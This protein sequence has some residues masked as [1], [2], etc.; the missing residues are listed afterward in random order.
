[1]R[2]IIFRISRFT[3]K[4]VRCMFEGMRVPRVRDNKFIIID[5]SSVRHRYRYINASQNQFNVRPLIAEWHFR[6]FK[7][8]NMPKHHRM[9]MLFFLCHFSELDGCGRSPSVQYGER[10]FNMQHR[11]LCYARIGARSLEKWLGSVLSDTEYNT[12]RAQTD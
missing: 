7:L 10:N 4:C 1:M 6:F 3:W 9:P 2:G 5:S 8:M 11:L 12:L